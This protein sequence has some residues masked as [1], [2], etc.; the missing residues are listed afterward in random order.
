MKQKKKPVKKKTIPQWQRWL[1]LHRRLVFIASF[2]LIGGCLV[3]ASF[4][5]TPPSYSIVVVAGQSN[6]DGA[7][8]FVLDPPTGFDLFGAKGHPADASTKLVWTNLVNNVGPP[9]TTLKSI[10][11]DAGKYGSGQATFGPE[12][13]LARGLYDQGRKNL[14]ILKVSYGG[15]SLGTNPNG[16]DWNVHSNNE[17]YASL[18]NRMKGVQA[19][20][21]SQGGTASVDGFYW[22]QGEGDTTPALAPQY[23]ANLRDLVTRSRADLGMSPQ[24]PFVIAKTSLAA[25]IKA[26]QNLLG[27][28]GSTSCAQLTQADQTVRAAQQKVAD[29]VPNTKAVD[30][31]SLPRNGLQI[32]LNNVGEL[33]LGGMMAQA[34]AGTVPAV[35]T[36][37]AA[38]S[39]ATT[40]S[41]P[42]TSKTGTSTTSPTVAAAGE[43]TTTANE[44]I[45]LTASNVATGKKVTKKPPSIWERVRSFFSL[46]IQRI[47]QFLSS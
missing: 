7:E 24:A 43:V 38:A 20:V 14:I 22:V 16:Q 19:W 25:W 28:C 23:E 26:A 39:A 30:T 41:A 5:A 15:L 3:Y 27:N 34:T 21:K 31:L 17:A 46:R 35:G 29:T 2:A 47:K 12:V 32:H 13:G 45:S 9:P 11:T 37:A 33:Q 1:S 10:G 36:A 8:S 44:P 18:V 4:A 40:K 42:T 6:A